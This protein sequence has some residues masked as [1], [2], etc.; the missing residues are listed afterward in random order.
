M[1]VEMSANRPNRKI[2]TLQVLLIAGA[3]A[4]I[5]LALLTW[6]DGWNLDLA[7]DFGRLLLVTVALTLLWELHGR[8]VFADEVLELAS[9]GSDVRAAGLRSVNM[10]YLEGVAWPEL[11]MGA[12]EIDLVVSWANTWRN[13][14]LERLRKVI[15]NGGKLRVLLP[16]PDD[17]AGVR[18]LA[19]QFD[20]SDEDV[21]KEIRRA[22]KEYAQLRSGGGTVE[23]WFRP[24][25]APWALY[26][27]GTTAVFTL[28]RA[29]RERGNVPVVVATQPG[30]LYTFAVD[31]IAA[32][33][34]VGRKEG[35]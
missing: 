20:M 7:A 18:S 1:R 10:N 13:Q 24:A 22:A 17:E 32:L 19:T 2:T 30:S 33:L 21:V 3:V 4:V 35:P 31:E 34:K 29:A 14:H 25:V 12:P 6:A 15:A 11:L 8:R 5:G 23:I 28:Y 27:V 26:R 9:V 16:D